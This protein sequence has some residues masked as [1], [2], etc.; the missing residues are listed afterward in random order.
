MVLGLCLIFTTSVYAQQFK[1]TAF[2][3][4]ISDPD[5]YAVINKN[6][7]QPEDVIADSVYKLIKI[8]YDYVLLENTNTK[9]QIKIGF[10]LG[11]KPVSN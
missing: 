1:Y 7:Y 6:I 10:Y 11:N 5:G 3:K 8:E 4:T 2:V 9:K